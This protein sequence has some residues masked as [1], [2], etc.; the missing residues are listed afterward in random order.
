MADMPL[1]KLAETPSTL[2]LGWT[3]PVGAVGYVL[4]A[5]GVRTSNSWDPQKRTWG[6]KNDG[7]TIRIVALGNLAEGVYPNVVP[8][9]AGWPAPPVP[10]IT[11]VTN[12]PGLGKNYT[13]RGDYHDLVVDGT[14][15]TA[16]LFQPG[17]AGS[18]L[19]RTRL[20]R[21]CIGNSVSY[22]KHAI[23]AKAAN[24]LIEDIYAECA[25]PAASGFSLRY[26]GAVLRRSEVHGAPHAITYYETSKKAGTVLVEDVRGSFRGDTGV[27]AALD[28]EPRVLQ[29]FTFRR[30]DLTGNGAFMKATAFG[31]SVLVDTC[32]L[33][34]KPVTKADL[35]GVPNVT[36]A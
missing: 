15:D 17:A 8:P 2:T 29:A 3:P 20:L 35:P 30:V 21:C 4:Y 7:K 18:S 12:A 19:E 11:T 5:D 1:T 25:S 23:Y 27:W 22:G 6:V 24:L 33:N 14:G 31:G 34:G 10:P 26:D 32:T 36:V 16:V 28:S 9:P 13:T